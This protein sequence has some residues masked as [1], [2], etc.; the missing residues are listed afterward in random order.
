M[1][2]E[3]LIH[4][5]IQKQVYTCFSFKE[6]FSIQAA[7]ADPSKEQILLQAP[8]RSQKIVL[9]NHIPNN[10]LVIRSIGTN[11]RAC[12]KCK[13]LPQTYYCESLWYCLGILN[14]VYKGQENKWIG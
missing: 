3:I 12:Q 9:Q 4:F 10:G 6:Y 11:L 7:T 13:I 2:L 1:N 8:F 14:S 5:G